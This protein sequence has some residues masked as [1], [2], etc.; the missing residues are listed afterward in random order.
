MKKKVLSIVL[1]ALTACS[2]LALASCSKS[3]YDLAVENG[4]VGT[5][6]EW[7]QSLKGA[8]G[9]DAPALTV[10]DIYDT[11]VAEGTF[12]G[13]FSEFLKQ[14]LTLDVPDNNDVETL[15]HNLLSTVSIFTSFRETS[16]GLFGQE[17]SS[18]YCAAGSGVIINLD[19]EK[20]NAT[21]ITNYHVVYDSE[22]SSANGIASDIYL[23]LYGALNGF[24]TTTGKDV[25]GDGIRAQFIGGSMD[26]DI[27][28]LQV[29][30]SEVLK[31]SLAEEAEFGDSNSATVGEKVFAIGN[32]EGLGIAVSQGVLSV[33]SEYIGMKSL[34]GA[35]RVVS[36]R[37]MRTDAATN[38]GN[39]GGPLFDCYG[40]LIA[41]VNAKSIAEGV[42]NM[43]FA[44]PASQVQGVM[45]NVLDN[46]GSVKRAMLGVEITISGTS[47]VMRD[48]GTL[49]IVEELTVSSVSKNSAGWNKLQKGD[50]LQSL[51]MDGKT[52]P[53][54]RRFY[55]T[56]LLLTADKGDTV[57]V[58]VLRGGVKTRVEIK[59][60]LARYFS[61][62]K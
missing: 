25:G 52:Y 22:S 57:Y 24:S 9:D 13:T 39:S 47:V 49:A 44:L 16:E 34:D 38:G 36:Y 27:A 19:K 14:Y 41:I 37:V 48:N 28:I 12:S 6:Q 45:D 55:V 29:S 33:D 10:K 43:G 51:E 23:Y 53:L 31:N 62:V 15:A 26:Y 60:D 4:F 5:E 42:E 56:D 40:K 11:A 17:D 8:D 7:L 3:P 58:N 61:A 21:V 18:V 35:N 50:V 54:E 30:G 20:G 32:P 46:G 1:A 2:A 59:F